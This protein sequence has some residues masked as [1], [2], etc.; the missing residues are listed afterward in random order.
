LLTM[1]PHPVGQPLLQI[2]IIKTKD[3]T[4]YVLIKY[5]FKGEVGKTNPRIIGIFLFR[6][7]D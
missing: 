5:D 7:N 4:E 2:K 6:E 1:S 3:M